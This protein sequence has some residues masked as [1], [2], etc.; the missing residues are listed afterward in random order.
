MTPNQGVVES[1]LRARTERTMRESA[2]RVPIERRSTR[3]LNSKSNAMT[4]RM[5]APNQRVEIA[6]LE[7]IILSPGSTVGNEVLKALKPS[8][9]MRHIPAA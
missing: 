6:F 1:H 7:T 8:I 9:V 2:S 3:S 5:R 4:A